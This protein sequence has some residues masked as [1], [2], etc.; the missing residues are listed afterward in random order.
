MRFHTDESGIAALWTAIVLLFLLGAT[1]LAVDTSEFFQQARSQQRAVDLACLAGAA[2][3]P[4]DPTMAVQKAADFVRPNQRGLMA[5]SPTSP[6]AAVGNTSTWITGNFVLE[7]ETPAQYNGAADPNVMRIS[8]TQ[9]APT[10]FGK[11]LGADSTGIRQDAFC[12]VSESAGG[13]G[14]L[15]MGALP[16]GFGGDLFDCAAK[17]TG[18][19]GA[20]APFGTGGSTYRDSVGAGQ[21]GEFEKHHGHETATDSATGHMVIPCPENGPCNATDTETGNMTGPFNQ[22]MD[23]RLANIADASC[24]ENGNFNCDSLTE[25][26]GEA[27]KTLEKALE[28]NEF[29][30][31]SAPNDWW[32]PSLY[33][34]FDTYKAQQYYWNGDIEKC[35]S[36]RLATVPIV[37]YNDNWDIGYPPLNWPNGRK[38]MKIIGFYTVYIREPDTAAELYGNGLGLTVADVIWF[39]PDATCDDV[40]MSPFGSPPLI[41]GVKLVAG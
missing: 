23:D 40:P 24:V 30:S 33:G 3:L 32:E 14:L 5:I 20:L 37:V 1:A 21:E 36:P 15:P 26:I 17:V 12:L 41:T 7:V 8:L 22:G 34:D 4:G 11:V 31:G 18:N 2:E 10:R 38:Q 19:C 25:V 16:N 29:P 27:P 28:D 9:Q 35:D 6:T 39:G 13:P